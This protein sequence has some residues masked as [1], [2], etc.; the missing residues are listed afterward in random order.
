MKK[1]AAELWLKGDISEKSLKKALTEEETKDILFGKKWVE[2][3][4]QEIR[5]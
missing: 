4:I 1:I 3:A 2:G 5:S